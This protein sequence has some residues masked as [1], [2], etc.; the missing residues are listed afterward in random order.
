MQISL[1]DSFARQVSTA[2]ITGYQKHISP[3]KG[4]ACAH[5]I[6][7][8][9][10]SCSG[11]F[12]RVIAKEG[13]KVAFVNSRERFQACKEANHILRK[14]AVAFRYVSM[15]IENS[16]ESTEEEAETQQRKQASGKVGQTSSFINSNN[17]ECFDCADLG[18]NCAEILN[19]APDCGAPDCSFLD[20]SGADCSFLDCG[21]CGS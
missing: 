20:C 11:Y 21:S 16:E 1:F 13:L 3:H 7:Y 15:S 6:L 12:K 19:I 4:F 2:A 8:G 14:R 18:C 17:T 9:G 5:R 10:E